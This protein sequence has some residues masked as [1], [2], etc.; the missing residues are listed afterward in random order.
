MSEFGVKLHLWSGHADLYVKACEGLGQEDCKFEGRDFDENKLETAKFKKIEGLSSL[1]EI[2]Y[3]VFCTNDNPKA[4]ITNDQM[5]E[6]KTFKT[7]V[8]S[9][10]LYKSASCTFLIGIHALDLG[11]KGQ[12]KIIR[13]D[14]SADEQNEDHLLNEDHFM[15]V[16]LL[17]EQYKYYKFHLVHLGPFT[18]KIRVSFDTFY[19]LHEICLFKG[20]VRPGSFEECFERRAYNGMG[21]QGLYS[22]YEIFEITKDSVP[23]HVLEGTYYIAI[24]ALSY[25]S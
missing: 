16:R 1:K 4:E 17:P 23:D 25:S 6:L 8:D 19:G 5:S 7:V 2:T 21:N 10:G 20:E 13:Y 15:R 14:I 3:P 9:H 18:K 11:S 22:N 24:H 12:T